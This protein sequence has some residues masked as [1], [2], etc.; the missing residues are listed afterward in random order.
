MDLMSW[1]NM[2]VYAIKF[3]VKPSPVSKFQIDYNIMRLANT[4]DNWYRGGQA[5]YFTSKA[6]NQE[7]SLGQEVDL[8]YWH[9]FKEKFK[10][11]IGYGVFHPGAYL[12]K[13]TSADIF[14]FAGSQGSASNGF[15]DQSQIVNQQ[16]GYVMGS[17]KF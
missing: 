7:A 15:G 4:A 2:V 9:T 17:I 11:E 5:V 1:K 10:F 6:T 8:H 13:S 16:W 14:G 3:D 12:T